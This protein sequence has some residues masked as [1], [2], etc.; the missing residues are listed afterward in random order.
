MTT[1]RTS[2]LVSLAATVVVLLTLGACVRPPS[3][4]DE[5][6]PVASYPLSIHF[7]NDARDYVH[8]YL[9][10]DSRQWLLGRVDPG[11]IATLRIP[12]AAI[13]GN[14]RYVRLAVIMGGR[15]TP[16]AVAD[17]RATVTVLQP[18]SAMVAHQW[19]FD[20]AEIGFTQLPTARVNRGR[21]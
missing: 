21:P 13:R 5:P 20:G 2:A 15:L 12:D 10:G 4:L 3:P 9:I 18:A 17:T 8:V 1:P 6:P 19:R 11:A 7:D 16:E 14:S